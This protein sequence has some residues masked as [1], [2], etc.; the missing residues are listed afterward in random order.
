M[1]K[2]KKKLSMENYN[3]EK[4]KILNCYLVWEVHPNYKEEVFRSKKKKLREQK[5]ECKQWVEEN[6]ND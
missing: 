5:Q 1:K 2:E 3:I 4:D 6:T